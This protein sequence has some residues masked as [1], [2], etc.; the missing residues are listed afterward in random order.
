MADFT[1][2]QLEKFHDL[3]PAKN[4][5]VELRQKKASYRAIADLLTRHHLPIGRTAITAFCHEVLGEP[6][7]TRRRTLRKKDPV[8]ILRPDE[9][10]STPPSPGSTGNEML[11]TRSRGPRIAQVRMLKNP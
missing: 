7:R 5:I 4:V 6:S 2:S 10:I 3:L 1:P 11:P 8:A 9:I